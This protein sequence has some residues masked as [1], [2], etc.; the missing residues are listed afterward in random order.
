MNTRELMSAVAQFETAVV[1]I[2]LAEVTNS[3]KAHKAT[4]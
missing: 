3:T 1:L 4:S 2:T